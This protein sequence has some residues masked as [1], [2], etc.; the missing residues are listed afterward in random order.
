MIRVVRSTVIDAPVAA[1]WEILRDFNGHDRWHPAVAESQIERGRPA[2]TVGCVRRFRLED[3]SVLRE[4]LLELSDI[5]TAYSYCLL[6]TP[7]PIF[8]Y[9]SRVRLLPVTDGDRTY[10]HWRGRFDTRP[11]EAA[12]LA[13]LVGDAI[14]QAGFDAI[15]AHLAGA[16]A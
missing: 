8:N 1:V 4:Q 5:E 7:I 15:R 3:G 16:R 13:A 14:Y 12:A 6:D 10:W 11:G 9:V 2:D